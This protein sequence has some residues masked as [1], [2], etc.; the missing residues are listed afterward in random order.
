MGRLSV[1]NWGE[2]AGRALSPHQR[3]HAT[4]AIS[5]PPFPLPAT[6][7]AR[8]G[9]ARTSTM[10]LYSWVVVAAACGVASEGRGGRP[11]R[12]ERRKRRAEGRSS[13]RWRAKAGAS[14]GVQDGSDG[15]SG[16]GPWADRARQIQG[17]AWGR[18]RR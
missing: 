6:T 12:R 17:G 10:V 7:L 13:H 2:A 15:G 1:A 11:R 14:G 18:H 8:R 4:V 9:P 16:E 3:A 5:L